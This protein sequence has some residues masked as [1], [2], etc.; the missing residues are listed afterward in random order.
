MWAKLPRLVLD[1]LGSFGPDLIG[2]FLLLLTLA[3]NPGGLAQQLK[4]VTRWMV[5][6]PFRVHEQPAVAGGR[7]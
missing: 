4:P 1:E 3:F 5:G 2:A 6:G 7:R